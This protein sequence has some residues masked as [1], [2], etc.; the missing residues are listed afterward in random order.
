MPRI[1][2]CVALDLGASGTR[3]RHEQ[4]ADEMETRRPKGYQRLEGWLIGSGCLGWSAMIRY[5]SYN[6][7]A[8]RA[9]M[10][11]LMF[12]MPMPIT[13]YLAFLTAAVI[14][15]LIPG[16]TVL[17]VVGYSVSHGRQATLPLVVAVGLGDATALAF[18]LFGLGALL[19]VSAFWF[20]VAKFCGGL[21]LLYLGLKSLRAGIR[22]AAAVA[23]PVGKHRL[24]SN[25]FLVTALNPKS[26][27]FFV[28]FLPQFVYGSGDVVDQLWLMAV[29]F[30]ML[31]ML[32]I[33]AYATFASAA[34]RRLTAPRAQRGFHFVG[35]VLLISAGTW[36]L[37]ARRQA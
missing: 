16:P 18:S 32:N 26:I 37:L 3:R 28:A 1:A 29:T 23:K 27:T 8:V 10:C 20:T 25:T 9:R 30:V 5:G 36:A 34:S 21:Y 22:P 13:H 11:F 24:F 12:E 15:L 31:A 14:L 7:F 35:G 19:K 6:R 2:T 33:A 17:T 4:L